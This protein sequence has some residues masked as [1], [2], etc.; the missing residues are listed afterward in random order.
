MTTFHRSSGSDQPIKDMVKGISPI[1]AKLPAA[2]RE[3]AE[4]MARENPLTQATDL[5]EKTK[6]QY[7]NKEQ[8]QLEADVA[9][10]LGNTS[11]TWSP[12]AQEP[13]VLLAQAAST[14]GARST[15]DATGANNGM[16][17]ID[18][19]VASST[20]PA[21]SG[22]SSMWSGAALIGGLL[23]AGLGGGSSKAETKTTA[24][25][26]LKLTVQDGLIAGAKVYRDE[27]ADKSLVGETDANGQ[28]E[29]KEPLSW[30]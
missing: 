8:D 15:S 25:T 28:L 16:K 7:K 9:A 29:L 10:E 30:R 18:W 12:T 23:V 14:D 13:G 11:G 2:H 4:K 19:G 1:H 17:N 20:T 24:D 26:S 6:D 22:I 21:A 27:I 3:R 5:P